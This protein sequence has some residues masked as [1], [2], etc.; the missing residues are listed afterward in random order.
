[1]YIKTVAAS[2]EQR[3]LPKELANNKKQ[4]SNRVSRFYSQNISQN[5]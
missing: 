3:A 4:Q 2:S 1:M 5:N